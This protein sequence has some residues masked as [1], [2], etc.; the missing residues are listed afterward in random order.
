MKEM[1]SRNERI[2]Q[3]IYLFPKLN[4]TQKGLNSFQ[5][6]AITIVITDLHK[7]YHYETN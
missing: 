2:Y 5:H 3:Y 4:A 7:I 6:Q 1:K